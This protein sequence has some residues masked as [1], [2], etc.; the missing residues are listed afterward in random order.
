MTTRPAEPV[1]TEPRPTAPVASL[2]R[3]S[4]GDRVFRTLLTAAAVIIPVLLALL[5][6]QL[7]HVEIWRIEGDKIVEQ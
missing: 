4:H 5:I 6:W 7:D 1:L 2:F 3:R